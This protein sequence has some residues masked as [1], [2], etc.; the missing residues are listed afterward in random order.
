[1]SRVLIIVVLAALAGC[2]SDEPSS[3]PGT[4]FPGTGGSGGSAGLGGAGGATDAG[5]DGAAGTALPE[6]GDALEDAETDSSTPDGPGPTIE[7]RVD[8]IPT[9]GQNYCVVIDANG[10]QCDPILGNPCDVSA[11]ET[12]DFD[13]ERF[14]C[15]PNDFGL[16]APCELCGAPYPSLCVPG[17]TCLGLGG[18]C[19]RYCCDNLQ[20]ALGEFCVMQPPTTVGICQATSDQV[21]AGF[22]GAADAGPPP[23]DAECNASASPGDGSCVTVGPGAYPC[24]PV[25]NDGCDEGSAC[26]A[27]AGSFACV[28]GSHGFELC[29]ECTPTSCRP[30]STCNPFL[31]CMK[32]CC[33]DADCAP[34]FCR[35]MD[36]V[37]G[38]GTCAAYPG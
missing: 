15:L 30:G 22:V 18:K 4:V 21:L 25:T 2:G 29:E 20:C 37:S 35:P 9:Q 7:C 8:P 13:G 23:Y 12:C 33:D 38:L 34:G 26:D 17:F 3:G 36:G 11:G 10:Y 31:G 14:R 28:V 6:G 16:V 19:S 1:M 27:V 32:Y 24:N 5:P